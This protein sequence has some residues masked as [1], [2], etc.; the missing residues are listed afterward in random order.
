MER[1]IIKDFQI[2]VVEGIVNEII[3]TEKEAKNIFG[4]IAKAIARGDSNKKDWNTLR[5]TS[6]I[7]YDSIGSADEAQRRIRQMSFKR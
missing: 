1:R 3:S 7:V 4:K 5:R 6:T 2:G